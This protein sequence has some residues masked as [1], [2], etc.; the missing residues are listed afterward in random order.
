MKRLLSLMLAA[1]ML[2]ALVVVPT[3]A[4]EATDEAA[5]TEAITPDTDWYDSSKS[6]FEISTAAQLLGFVE[7]AQTEANFGQDAASTKKTVRLTADI[8][9]NPGT[10]LRLRKGEDGKYILPEKPVN[11][12]KGF[13]SWKGIFD[14]NGHVISGVYIAAKCNY[15]KKHA[16]LFGIVSSGG[17]V[18]NLIVENSFVLTEDIISGDGQSAEGSTASGI[19]QRVQYGATVENLWVDMDVVTTGWAGGETAGVAGQVVDNNN[20]IRNVVF[21][22]TVAALKPDLLD[23]NTSGAMAVSQILA[24]QNWKMKTSLDNVAMLGTTLCREGLN[25]KLPICL[26]AKMS[27]INLHAVYGR[28]MTLEDATAAGEYWNYASTEN[29]NLNTTADF[30]YSVFA[31]GVIP[32]AVSEMMAKMTARALRVVGVQRS[33]NSYTAGEGADAYTAQ[34]LRFV[35]GIRFMGVPLAD[36]EKVGFLIQIDENGTKSHIK[37]DGTTVY[38]SITAND[39]T[40]TA[41]QEDSDYLVALSVQ[42]VP[43][44]EEF[45]LTITPYLIGKDGTKWTGEAV[46]ATVLASGAYK[47]EVPTDASQNE[48]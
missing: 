24:N 10:T 15:D 8:D 1:M 48:N 7:L 28:H 46:S 19:A 26:N 2:F 25:G 33:Q 38:T 36:F 40:V 29:T 43:I 47:N 18:K 44:G 42:N 13:K 37:V 30:T 41:K 4:A 14:G 9:L 17:C 23:F 5:T 27:E 6:E 32:T 16:S 39:K 22:G 35:A 11:V 21:A 12:W 34:S 45:T 20:I 3:T 31:G